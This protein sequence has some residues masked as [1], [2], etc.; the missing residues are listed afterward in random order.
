MPSTLMIHEYEENTAYE[1]EY[2]YA[3]VYPD[4]S[5]QK[6][7]YGSSQRIFSRFDGFVTS[8]G[9]VFEELGRFYIEGDYGMKYDEVTQHPVDDLPRKMVLQRIINE[10]EDKGY[11]APSGEIALFMKRKNPDLLMRKNR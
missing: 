4:G 3:V 9:R 6:H 8:K 11:Y 2:G 5:M 10:L 1:R 7:K